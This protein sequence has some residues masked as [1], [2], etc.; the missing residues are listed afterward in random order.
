MI[1]STIF[2]K[3]I[4]DKKNGNNKNKHKITKKKLKKFGQFFLFLLVLDILLVIFALM[5]A[6]QCLQNTLRNESSLLHYFIA[7]FFPILYIIYSFIVA[8]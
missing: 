2:G 7:F 1:I 4:Q 3:Y 6:R 5:R 8:C